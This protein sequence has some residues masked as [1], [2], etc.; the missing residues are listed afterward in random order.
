M[1]WRVATKSSN[2]RAIISYEPG[3]GFIKAMA[4]DIHWRPLE[5]RCLNQARA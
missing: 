2:V 4:P 1:G 3:S 5:M